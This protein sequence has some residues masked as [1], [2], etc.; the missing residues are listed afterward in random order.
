[1]AGQ[2]RT[3]VVSDIVKVTF[4]ARASMSEDHWKEIG[5]LLQKANEK[6]WSVVSH[7]P[8]ADLPDSKQSDSGNRPRS[9][10]SAEDGLCAL[11]R[12]CSHH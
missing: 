5:A 7:E 9:S 1:M 10:N 12:R 6:R 11:L 3:S 4:R 8:S 2:N